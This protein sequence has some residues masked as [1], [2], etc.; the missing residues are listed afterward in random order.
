MEYV[1]IA[2]VAL[3]AAGLTLFS[4]F[5]LGTLLL[6][7]FAVFFSPEVAIGATAVVH[8]AN[9]CFKLAL[10]G[11]DAD[12]RVVV[13]FGLPA[14]AAAVVGALLLG[15]LA[16]F[17]DPIV[18]YEV[19]GMA[20]TVTP[21]GLTVGVL[22][23]LFAVIEW[24]PWV[25]RL[26]VPAKYLPVGGVFSG[27]F[28]G[29]SGHQGALRAAFLIR[30]GLSRDQFVATAAVCSAMVDFTRLVVY[31]GGALL[32]RRAAGQETATGGLWSLVGVGCV[33]AFVGSFLGVRLVKKVT[34]GW[35][36]LF[37]AA[38]LG[39]FGVVMASGVL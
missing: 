29:L 34:L 28:G 20:A 3:L 4:G 23:M 36:R 1:L 31:A 35:L 9:N 2:A 21:V 11:R 33:S 22:I 38:A 6:P 19:A 5:G 15:Q 30:S 12:R 10:I 7:A 13:R 32:L 24:L 25:K 16:R 8:F 26:E 39:V 27:F 14:V 17:N 18:G 37:V